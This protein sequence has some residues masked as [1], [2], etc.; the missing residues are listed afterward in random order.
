MNVAQ[1]RRRKRLERVRTRNS[2]INMGI[3]IGFSIAGIV[4]GLYLAQQLMPDHQWFQ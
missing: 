1:K 2:I 3:I 4:L